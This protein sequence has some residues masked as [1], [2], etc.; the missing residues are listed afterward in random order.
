VFRHGGAFSKDANIGKLSNRLNRHLLPPLFQRVSH[1]FIV[2]ALRVHILN[3]TH[4]GA[5]YQLRSTQYEIVR[6][7][8]DDD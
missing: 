1:N 5:T 2:A 8:D 6:R 3:F 7:E 4:S